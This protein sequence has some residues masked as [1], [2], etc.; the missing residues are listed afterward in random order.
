M[1]PKTAPFQE[2][3]DRLEKRVLGFDYGLKRI[4]SAAGN[5]A[6]GTCQG[7]MTVSARDGEPHWP[8]IARLIDE[9]KP[10]QLV[11]GLPLSMDGDETDMSRSAREFGARLAAKSGLRV[12]F[13]DERLTSMTADHLLQ[14]SGR[15]GKSQRK[16]HKTARD[17]L[18][19]E[20]I[21]QTY[22]DDNQ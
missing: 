17:N 13:V 4:G 15:P 5:A 12:C 9:W 1:E 16:R 3:K 8:V 7:L 14:E 21:L 18:A 22:F 19:A 20:L 6:R 10:G 11:V 2:K